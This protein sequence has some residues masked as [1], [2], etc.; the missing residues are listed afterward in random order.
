MF[1]GAEKCK[2]VLTVTQFGYVITVLKLVRASEIMGKQ[3]W[4]LFGKR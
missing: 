1:R 3:T 2:I 4:S